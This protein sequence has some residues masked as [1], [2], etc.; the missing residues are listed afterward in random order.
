MPGSAPLRAIAYG[1]PRVV[2]QKSADGSLHCRSAEALAPHDPSLA[3][4]FRRAVER[5]PGRLFLAERLAGGDWRKLSY[6]A[7]RP[8]VD[9]LAQGLIERGLSAEQ[10]VA[11][12]VNGFCRE[13]LQ[14]LPMEF[15]VEAQ[16]L[17]GISLEGSVG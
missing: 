5:N 7:T 8:L 3:R 1:A 2:C 4:L 11:L 12:I 9:A 13:V 14:E 6:E 16:K 10:A 15:A 17:V